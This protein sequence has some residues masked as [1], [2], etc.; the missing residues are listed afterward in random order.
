MKIQ[1]RFCGLWPLSRPWSLSQVCSWG[2]IRLKP[3]LHKHIFIHFSLLSHCY[4]QRNSILSPF[5]HIHAY[6][7]RLSSP[8]LYRST[9]LVIR[10]SGVNLSP[11]SRLS[12]C[13][14]IRFVICSP[15]HKKKKCSKKCNKNFN[16]N[17]NTKCN[18]HT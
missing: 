15:I 11:M 14:K 18:K 3:F 1:L 10:M 17:C 9:R 7:M 16:K 5:L 13:H 4:S 8:N 2:K 12:H 6:P